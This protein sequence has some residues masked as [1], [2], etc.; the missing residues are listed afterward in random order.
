MDIYRV[1]TGP[2]WTGG[3]V[4]DGN[5]RLEINLLFELCVIHSLG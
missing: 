5:W 2:L 4:P 3:A 1:F